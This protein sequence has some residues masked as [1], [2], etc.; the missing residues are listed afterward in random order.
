MHAQRIPAANERCTTTAH[1][2]LGRA[3]EDLR[4]ARGLNHRDLARC[5]RVQPA[6]IRALHS[7][8]LGSRIA[9]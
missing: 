5:T 4:T 1:A 9:R 8:T 6:Y 7:T 2:C 3:V